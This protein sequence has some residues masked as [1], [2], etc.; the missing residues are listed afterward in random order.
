MFRYFIQKILAG[1]AILMGVIILIFTLFILFPSA[2]EITAGQRADEATKLAMRAEMGLD[3]SHTEQFY[4]YLKDLSPISFGAAENQKKYKGISLPIGENSLL[5][6][7]PYLRNSYQTRKPVALILS[8]GLL[9]S[10]ILALFAMG[11]ALFLGIGTGIISALNPG[12]LSDKFCLT[13]ATLGISLPSFFV[14]VIIAWLF[15]YVWH[16]TTGLPMSGSLYQ[17]DPETG[18]HFIAFNHIWL[19]AFALGIRPYAII[20]QLTR[21]NLIEVMQQDYIR[22]AKAKGLSQINIIWNHALRNTLNPVLTAA[23][24]WFASL[25]AGAFFIEY[26]FNWKGLGKITIDALQQSDLPVV[27][28]AVLVIAFIFVLVNILVDILYAMLD[29]RVKLSN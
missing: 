13:L 7:W 24:G 8:E 26:V 19:P 5:I 28:G 4:L 21:S 9:G 6:K 18:Q 27:M 11:L 22:T 16:S 15:G 10:G 29:P 1:L 25:L 12:S 17:I 14:A 3:K 2:E 20:M 23:S